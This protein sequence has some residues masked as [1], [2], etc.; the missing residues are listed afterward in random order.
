MIWLLWTVKVDSYSKKIREIRYALHL[1][2]L[3]K[4]VL[5]Q[6]MLTEVHVIPA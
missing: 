3:F 4:L 1:L 2:T 5:Q 6:L